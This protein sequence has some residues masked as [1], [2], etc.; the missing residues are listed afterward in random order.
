MFF[1]YYYYFRFYPG[2]DREI[3]GCSD[4]NRWVSVR[5]RCAISHCVDT[6]RTKWTLNTNITSFSFQMI[7]YFIRKYYAL[8][9]V[10]TVRWIFSIP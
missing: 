3:F 4:G 2:H 10:R 1:Y 9:R 7:L 5:W 8:S 6:E